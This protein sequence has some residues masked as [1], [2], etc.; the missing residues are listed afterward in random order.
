MKIKTPHGDFYFDNNILKPHEMCAQCIHVSVC[1]YY[2]ESGSA[3]L[4]SSFKEATDE[5]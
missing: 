1:K 5:E 3:S 4:C 2:E